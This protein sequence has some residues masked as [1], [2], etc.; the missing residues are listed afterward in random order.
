MLLMPCC[1]SPFS[2]S[3]TTPTF[4]KPAPLRTT[5][6]TNNVYLLSLICKEFFETL[7]VL[8]VERDSNHQDLAKN[9]L[10]SVMN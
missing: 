4:S 3:N 7:I 2:S 6:I 9:W 1:P 5:I 8:F 10:T